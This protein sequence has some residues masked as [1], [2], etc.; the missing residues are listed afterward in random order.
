MVLRRALVRSVGGEGPELSA[1]PAQG[2]AEMFVSLFLGTLR[3]IP[4]LMFA[5]V[6]L[7]GP[8]FRI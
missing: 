7:W 8:I 5:Y 1:S 4:S 3:G 6:L 2:A